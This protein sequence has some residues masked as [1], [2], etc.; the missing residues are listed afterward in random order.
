[1]TIMIQR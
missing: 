1:M